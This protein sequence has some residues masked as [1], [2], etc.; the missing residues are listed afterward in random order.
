MRGCACIK[1]RYCPILCK[2]EHPWILVTCR[3]SCYHPSWITKDYC[4]LLIDKSTHLVIHC[5][6]EK[7]PYQLV[8]L[9]FP[10]QSLDHSGY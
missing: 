1:C 10:E 3:R 6:S 5:M 9:L 4:M 8:Y 7:S 2:T